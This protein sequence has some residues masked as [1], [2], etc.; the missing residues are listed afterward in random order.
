MTEPQV[1]DIKQCRCE[2]NGRQ[3]TGIASD[4]YGIT[5]KAESTVIPGLIGEAGFNIDPSTMAEASVSL[6]AASPE[7]AYLR[8]IINKQQTGSQGPVSFEIIV[9]DAFI[10]GFGF[11]TKGMKFAMVSMFPE[12]KTDE[13]SAPVYEYKFVGYGYQEK[14]T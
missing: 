10:D 2:V 7:N 4:G 6:N 5:P 13:K 1:F 3:M 14:S 9:D 12:F 11:K 8:D